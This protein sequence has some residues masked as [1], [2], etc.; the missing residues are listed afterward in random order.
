LARLTLSKGSFS[1]DTTAAATPVS[2]RPILTA[3]STALSK[4]I[5]RNE[6]FAALYILG[7]ANGLLGRVIL[8]TSFR[9]G[10]APSPD[11]HQR[12]RL[13]GLLCGISMII[14]KDA[15]RLRPRDLVV[16][17]VFRSWSSFRSSR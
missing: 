13:V 4:S 11:R 16:G 1:V 3:L 8:S 17:A 5:T 10:K 15:E 12:D 14:G 7:C 2:D 6:F 9:T